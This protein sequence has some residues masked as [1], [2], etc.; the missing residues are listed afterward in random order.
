[1]VE[2]LLEQ[3]NP[4]VVENGELSYRDALKRLAFFALSANS[5]CRR[6]ERNGFFFSSTSFPKERAVN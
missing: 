4:I 2:T 6:K 1:M 3:F 5:R